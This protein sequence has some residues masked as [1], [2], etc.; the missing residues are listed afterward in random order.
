MFTIA[1]ASANPLL[2]SKEPKFVFQL[3]L[4]EFSIFNVSEMD[5]LLKYGGSGE[6]RLKMAKELN[7]V[8]WTVTIDNARLMELL[9]IFLGEKT[10]KLV[11]TLDPDN[12]DANQKLALKAVKSLT[13]KIERA[14]KNPVWDGVML[15]GYVMREKENWNIVSKDGLAK[16]TGDRLG[17][18]KNL[19][20]KLVVAS[21]FIKVK[22]QFEVTSFLEKRKD[23]LELFVMSYCPFGQRAETALYTFLDQSNS[24]PKPNVEVH[25]IF[26]KQKKGGQEV[27]ASLHGEEEL[28]ENLV[29]IILRDRFPNVFE[30]YIRLRAVSGH[31]SWSNLANQ[32]GLTMDNIAEIGKTLASERESLM[33]KEYDYATGRY[34]IYDGSPTYVWESERVTDIHKV[35]AFKGIATA[36]N[37]ACS[38]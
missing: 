32:V 4:N 10:M 6:F 2:E 12:L 31:L 13:Q 24:L 15:S 38:H 16:I 27:F 20:G 29:Q 34:G 5:G 23:T 19:E 28:T 33:Q 1:T 7:E 37:E 9:G 17:G 26:Y 18:L 14:Q 22:G 11:Q 3:N 36:G 8:V 21:G 25:Y 30:P 35:E